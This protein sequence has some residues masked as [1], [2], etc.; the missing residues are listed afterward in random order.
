MGEPAAAQPRLHSRP[1]TAIRRFRLP[2]GIVRGA[3]GCTI[4]DATRALAG[5]DAGVVACDVGAI[6]PPSL[7]S[8]AVLA[9]LALAAHRQHRELRL[10]HASPEILDLI[11]LC[12]LTEVFEPPAREPPAREVPPGVAPPEPVAGSGGEVVG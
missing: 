10:E 2:G 4:E 3:V 5:C 7:P 12:G 1:T 6:D 11:D 9:A 8:V